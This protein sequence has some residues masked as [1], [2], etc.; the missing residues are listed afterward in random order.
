MTEEL[1]TKLQGMV[2]SHDVVLFMKGNRQQPQCGFSARVVNIFEE[3]GIDYQTYNVFSDPDIRS[4]MKDFSHYQPFHNS[5]S[6]KNS[7]GGCDLVT[8]MMQSGELPSMLGITLEDVEPP[9]IH[10][11]PNILQLFKESLAQHDGGGGGESIWM[12]PKILQYDIFIG[13]KSNGQV[14]TI[15]EGIPFYL[16]RGSAKR[17]KTAS[18]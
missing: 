18:P 17:A 15:V 16:S 6:S 4:G 2:D 1:Q 10:C 9:T 11:S 3:L 13:P 14:E 12:C 8:E 7:V 5:M